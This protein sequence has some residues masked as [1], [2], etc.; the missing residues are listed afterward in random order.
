MSRLPG[1][2]TAMSLLAATSAPH[3]AEGDGI[4]LAITS[5]DEATSFTAEC[6]I[7]GAEGERSESFDRTTPMDVTFEG[8]RGLRCRIESTG[9]LE[10]TASGGGNVSRTR[11]SGGTVTLNLGR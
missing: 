7:T 11:T 5:P 2:A 3:A 8:A 4:S 1:L 10:V 9:P 6:T